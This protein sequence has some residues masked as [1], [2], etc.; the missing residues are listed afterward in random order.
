MCES[1]LMRVLGLVEHNSEWLLTVWRENSIQHCMWLI[2]TV[3]GNCLGTKSRVPPHGGT[4]ALRHYT[5]SST[6]LYSFSM[7]AAL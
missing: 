3:V 2:S 7:L 6:P 4:A 1:V 5:A